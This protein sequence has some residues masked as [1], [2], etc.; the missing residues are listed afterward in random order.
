MRRSQ[1]V[2]RAR[3]AGTN[4]HADTVSEY[5]TFNGR[6]KLATGSVLCKWNYRETFQNTALIFF[7]NAT[8]MLFRDQQ[9]RSAVFNGV[10]NIKVL[11]R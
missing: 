4:I 2:Q 3:S 1:L 6:V 8:A 7:K 10:R 11:Q 5:S 9:A